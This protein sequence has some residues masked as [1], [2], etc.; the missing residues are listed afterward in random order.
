V[1]TPPLLRRLGAAACLA[2]SAGCTT[3]DLVSPPPR[4]DLY[5]AAPAPD[6]PLVLAIPGL[7]IPGLRIRQEEHFGRLVELLAE[8]G[9]PC[10]ILA[11]DTSGDPVAQHAALYSSEH[12]L[13]WTRVGPALAREF[14][15]ENERRLARGAPPVKRLVLIGYSQGSVLLAQLANRLFHSFKEEYRETVTAFGDEWEA[16]RKDPEFLLFINA[17]DDFI[18]IQNIRS[19]NEQLFKSSPPLRRLYE[20]AQKKLVT[21]YEEFLGYL[22]DPSG[23]YPGV[24]RF[25]GVESPYY[26]KRYRRIRAYAAERASRT[27]EE[28]EKNRQ[29]F[30]TYAQY[31]SLLD[32]EARFISC[33]GSLFGSPQAN[34]TVNLAKWL[35]FVRRVI[36]RE[37]RQILQTELGTEEHLK[38]VERLSA[39]AHRKRYPFAPTEILSI[40]GANGAQGDGLVDQPAAHLSLHT[41]AAFKTA[42]DADG[43]ARLDEVRRATLPKLPVAPLELMHLPEKSFWGLAGRRH[44]AAYMVEDN[45]A[46]PFVLNFIRGDWASL[47]RD[48]ARDGDLFRQ[49]MVEVVL[50]D[51][52]LKASDV[53]WKDAS[54]DLVIR[55]RYYNEG[56]RTIIWTGHFK[57]TGVVAELREKAR[58]L[59]VTDMV[60][61]VRDLLGSSHAERPRL[62][63]N[64]RGRVQLLNPA[65]LIPNHDEIF[66]WTGLVPE[67]TEEAGGLV[68]FSVRLPGGGEAPLRCAVHPGRI[69]F[70]KI[71]A[72][73]Q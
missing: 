71:E 73:E 62:L 41:F 20:R 54:D 72:G 32:V 38:R 31:R 4:I 16:L 12:G 56:S 59:D 69:S 42:H 55:G 9:I 40:V 35:P 57:D 33:A 30:V 58:L 67:E 46:W 66:S 34:D 51:A 60:P 36:G 53:R 19:Q 68:D 45:P 63:E 26:P 50:G 39:D 14:E 23:K 49:F 13:A 8:Q 17:L 1:D 43:K 21:Q 27:A 47:E 18:A 5:P 10:R 61:G 3:L 52:R 28:K 44:G 70:V 29:F 37:Y 15:A 7:R 2:L 11:Y 65:P 24:Q 22:T 25:E 48:L 6:A 64:L